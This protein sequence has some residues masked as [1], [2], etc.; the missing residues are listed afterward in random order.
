VAY[1]CSLAATNGAGTGTAA[2]AVQVTPAFN[3]GILPVLM[4]LLLD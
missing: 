3:D 2:A 4:I 1:S